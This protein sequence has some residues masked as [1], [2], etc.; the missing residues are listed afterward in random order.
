MELLA[1]VFVWPLLLL[2]LGIVFIS[3]SD[4]AGL[5]LVVPAV[6]VF[7]I[8]IFGLTGRLG[9]ADASAGNAAEDLDHTRRSTV[10]FSIALLLPIFVKYLLATTQNSLAG[11]ILG[12]VVGF[13]VLVWG[14]FLKNNK[15]LSYANVLGGIF[16]IVY[17]YFQLGTLGQL[18]QVIA[19][20]FGL[21]VAVAISIIKFREKLV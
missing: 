1:L 8:F 2:V 16:V 3:T 15:V 14:M 19:A 12:L 6:V 20:A 5:T 7:L 9:E 11:M 10:S 21:I 4:V 13:G 17:L 18:A